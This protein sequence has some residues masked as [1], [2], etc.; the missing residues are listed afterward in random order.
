MLRSRFAW[1]ALK[2]VP[3]MGDRLYKR[4]IDRLGSPEAVLAAN[5]TDL[6]STE[7]M[8]PQVATAIR[9]GIRT[10]AIDLELEAIE[11]DKISL[12]TIKDPD[13]PE[14]L[15]QVEDAP[16]YLYI[17]GRFS[18]K[19]KMAIAIVGS[20]NCSEYGRSVAYN[21]GKELAERGFTVVSGM[22]RGIDAAAHEGALLG[23][24]RTIGVLGCGIDVPYPSDHTTLKER[25]S[26]QGVLL[27]EFPM[28]TEPHPG[29][30][31]KRN[32]VISGLSLGVIVVEAARRSGAL[33]TANCALDQ[34]REVF[35]VP[36]SIKA[37]GSRGTH[38][39]IKQGAKLVERIEDIMEEIEGS[40]Q[41]GEKELVQEK[42]SY[43]EKDLT[44]SVRER[45]V[46]DILSQEPQNINR[47]TYCATIP[48]SEIAGLLLQLE[49]KGFVQQMAG[50]R[51]IRIEVPRT[52]KRMI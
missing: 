32:R 20:R 1:L 52:I 21:F 30:F 6:L 36:G 18:L 40:I 51:Y 47:L 48:P 29:N 45:K 14:R 26:R 50:H 9:A 15:W 31:P 2:A 42:P 35:A 38:W 19:D 39:L 25:V 22:A 5:Q 16:P 37:E 44:L 11:K 28:G 13:Y 4:L 41:E 3:G 8:G 46:Y 27:S 43:A 10:E 33:I 23:G 7:G 12:C 24:G 34:G 17:R 49:L